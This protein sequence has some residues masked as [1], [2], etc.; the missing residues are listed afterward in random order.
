MPGMDN[1]EKAVQLHRGNYNCCQAVVCAFA[2][3][4]GTDEVLLFRIAEGFGGGTATTR[5]ICGALNGA[6]MLAGLRNS[7]GNIGN[8]ASKGATA[9]LVRELSARFEEKT[10]ALICRELKGI[11]T[12]RILCPC[13]ECVRAGAECVKEVL[14]L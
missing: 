2:G 9:G 11:D 14:G 13:S 10:G 1:V 7:D 4:V 12:H 6:V 8:P 5:G 3:E